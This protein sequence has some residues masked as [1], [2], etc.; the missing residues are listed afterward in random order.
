[1]DMCL[2]SGFTDGVTLVLQ[3][4]VG[5]RVCSDISEKSANS[6]V[7]ESEFRSVDCWLSDMQTVSVLVVQNIA[8]ILVRKLWRNGGEL[9]YRYGRVR[10]LLYW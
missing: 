2:C 1:M 8:G 9:Q 7:M 4:R 10:E 5:S 3:H 6:T